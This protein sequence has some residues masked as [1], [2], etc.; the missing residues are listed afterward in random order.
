MDSVVQKFQSV[1]T[2]E[3]VR[4]FDLVIGTKYPIWSLQNETTRYG[5]SLSVIIKDGNDSNRMLNVYLPKRYSK[6]FTG[7]E[8]QSVQPDTL[9]LQYHGQKDRVTEVNIAKF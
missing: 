9:Y 4:F 7:E 3:Y 8:L 5:P 2:Y 6:K 1:T